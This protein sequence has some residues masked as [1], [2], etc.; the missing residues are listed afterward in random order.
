M[1]EQSQKKAKADGG[2][3]KSKKE[4]AERSTRPARRAKPLKAKKANNA[5]RVSKPKAV[6]SLVI[7]G[8]DVTTLPLAVVRKAL[9][10][11]PQDPV[12]FS[13]TLRD[14][15]D[16]FGEFSDEAIGDAL[17]R[18]H[19]TR[20]CA[21]GAS[22]ARTPVEENGRNFSVGERQL[23]CLARALLTNTRFLLI[24]EATANVDV[25]TDARIQTVI[26]EE[27]SHCT[28]LTIAHR[29]GTLRECHRIV[30]LEEGR[31]ARI[32]EQAQAS[33]SD[34]NSKIRE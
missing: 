2:S 1:I 4:K 21:D 15:L 9:T 8:I 12:L 16:P 5:K 30:E 32:I 7:D 24:D 23:V 18:S 29:L 25:E 19:L 17:R 34:L 28:I 13:G 11:I 20:I 27:F 6:K 31:V 3:K 33:G 22:A 14:N 10:V 26:R